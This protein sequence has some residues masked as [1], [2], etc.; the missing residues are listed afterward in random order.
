MKIKC[1]S[2]SDNVISFTTSG[3]SYDYVGFFKTSI[4][5]YNFDFSYYNIRSDNKTD[6]AELKTIINRI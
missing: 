2:S 3:I 4:N 5:D 1:F 6:I